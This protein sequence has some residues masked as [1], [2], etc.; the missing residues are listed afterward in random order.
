MRTQQA[1][2]LQK[3]VQEL[4][5]VLQ[6]AQRYIDLL[7]MESFV[8]GEEFCNCHY[9]ESSDPLDHTEECPIPD[10]EE[11]VERIKNVLATRIAKVGG[12]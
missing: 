11:V 12:Q 6:D 3:R 2:T 7:V 5:S 1:V 8:Y 10:A 4:E 9:C